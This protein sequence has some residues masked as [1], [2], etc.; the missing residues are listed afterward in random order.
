M[1]ENDFKMSV[2]CVKEGERVVA[3][4][5]E[6]SIAGSGDSIE[7]AL[8]AFAKTVLAQLVVNYNF[9]ET[10]F[11]GC[12]PAPSLFQRTFE[13][14]ERYPAEEGYLAGRISFSLRPSQPDTAQEKTIS[15]RATPPYTP[16]AH[17]INA[18]R[19]A[20]IRVAGLYR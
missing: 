20:D 7:D 1:E 12:K 3:F 9:G 18:M 5:L 2:L 10:S 14:A 8:E 11:Q 19:Q 16:P 13:M 15:S 17:I 6:H 4:C